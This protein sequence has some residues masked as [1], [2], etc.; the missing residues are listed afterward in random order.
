LLLVVIPVLLFF[1]RPRSTVYGL[2]LTGRFADRIIEVEDLGDFGNV[3]AVLFK[4][5]LP[6]PPRKN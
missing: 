6:V 1:S 2:W 3:S 5:D 4:L